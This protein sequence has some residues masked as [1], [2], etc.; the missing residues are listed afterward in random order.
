MASGRV[1]KEMRKGG[2]TKCV[3]EKKMSPKG[4]VGSHVNTSRTNQLSSN[5]K[6]IKTAVME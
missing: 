4:W 1:L 5:Y 3:M 2:F 6:D